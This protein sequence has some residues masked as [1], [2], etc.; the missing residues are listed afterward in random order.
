MNSLTVV[1]A[2]YARM[3]RLNSRLKRRGLLKQVGLDDSQFQDDGLE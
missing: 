3:R 2:Q 1:C